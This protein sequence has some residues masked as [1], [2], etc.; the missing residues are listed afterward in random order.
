M[1]APQPPRLVG[2][3]TNGAYRDIV[4]R[5]EHERGRE[6]RKHVARAQRVLAAIAAGD[7]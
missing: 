3:R 2:G 4:A 1:K 7:A 6:L 5:Y